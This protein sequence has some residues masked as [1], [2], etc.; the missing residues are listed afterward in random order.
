MC[1]ALLTE[2]CYKVTECVLIGWERIEVETITKGEIAMFSCSIGLVS[3]ESQS[4]LEQLYPADGFPGEVL[5][6]QGD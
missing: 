5:C 4:I 1:Q 2:S 6:H 3:R